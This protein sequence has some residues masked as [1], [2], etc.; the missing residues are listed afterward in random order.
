MSF[1]ETVAQ[2]LSNKNQVDVIYIDFQKAFDLLHHDVLLHKLHS[3]GFHQSALNFFASYLRDREQYVKFRNF[4]SHT[5][6]IHTGVPQGTKL[7]P[8]LFLVGIHDLPKVIS[9]SEILLLADDAKLFREILN[10]LDSALLQQD[11][12]NVVDWANNNL[13]QINAS[14]TATLSFCRSNRGPNFDTRY[15]FQNCEI[16]RVHTVTDLGII[17]DSRFTFSAHITHLI[18]QCYKL[19]GFLMR[20]TRTVHD[21]DLMVILYTALI[22]SKLEFGATLWYPERANERHKIEQIQARFVRLLFYRINGFYPAYPNSI[23]YADLINHL[24]ISAFPERVSRQRLLFVYKLLNGLYTDRT[25]INLIRLRV[26]PPGLR[27][28]PN[29]LFSTSHLGPSSSLARCLELF[30]ATGNLDPFLP[31][32]SFH[33]QIQISNDG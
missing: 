18:T 24:N 8:K 14:K 5:F 17:F 15:Y 7:G 16:N 27:A 25:L 10:L 13:F 6:S 2:S 12:N 21:V 9:H 26:T 32:S 31:L 20:N 11:F 28:R 29:S 19:L 30:N 4:K 22:R 23:S 33:H 1:S 3:L